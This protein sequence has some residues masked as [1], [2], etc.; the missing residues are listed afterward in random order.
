MKR[1]FAVAGV[2]VFAYA[3]NA[4][5]VTEV[6][7]TIRADGTG[8][9]TSLSAWETAQQK[10]LVASDQIAVARIEG[11]WSQADGPV[12]IDGWTTDKEHYIKITVAGVA[13]H[14]GIWDDIRYR[15]SGS[16][17]C[18][19]IGENYV[20]IDGIQILAGKIDDNLITGIGCAAGLAGTRI[21]NCI[22]RLNPNI[23]FKS[24]GNYCT[25]IQMGVDVGGDA[26]VSNNMVVGFKV[27]NRTNNHGIQVTNHVAG[28]TYAYNNTVYGCAVGMKDGYGSVVAKNN[29]V[30]NCEDNYSGWFDA[31][32]G[33]NL[34]GP[35]Q[36]DAPGSNP[37]NAA[38]VAF[39]DAAAG[40]FRLAST[41]AGAKD[42]GADLSADS[43][44]PFNTDIEGNARLA[45]WDIGA[46]EAV[47][48][49]PQNVK[50]SDVIGAAET[51]FTAAYLAEN[52]NINLPASPIIARQAN[53]TAPALK[54]ESSTFGGDAAIEFS[55]Q[56]GLTRIAHKLRLTNPGEFVMT[57]RAGNPAIAI[58]G[59]GASEVTSIRGNTIALEA[60]AKTRVSG[61]M[62]FNS[63]IGGIEIVPSMGSQYAPVIR[64]LGLGGQVTFSDHVTVHPSLNVIGL[65]G[66]GDARLTVGGEILCDAIK[67][68]NWSIEAPD[69]VFDENHKI[70]QIGELAAFLSK[71]KH[72]PGIPSA[73]EMKE[74]GVDLS[75]LNMM[76]LEKIEELTLYVIQ[77]DKTIAMQGAKI[78]ELAK[79]K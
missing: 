65:T 31:S 1:L 11:P 3:L 18:V 25:G 13:R 59:E 23:S 46:S 52:Q 60:Q 74:Q 6:V 7:K 48:S 32:G 4:S 24:Y 28:K 38:A 5:A 9:Y 70:M 12:T 41:D 21:T 40:N 20:Q 75:Q 19:G 27:P 22:V 36:N 16:N 43:H 30:Y 54:L 77:Q 37:R 26:F 76:L 29:L 42:F 64:A 39:V 45:P 63:G 49:Y 50:R 44:L 69:Y 61:I 62:E 72:L 68:K 79:E 10:N 67:I 58:W 51:G 2:F 53:R 34:S 33:N 8:D 17:T 55:G 73:R 78:E 57:D 35:S 56:Y 47:S 14:T 15:I 66:N 71:N